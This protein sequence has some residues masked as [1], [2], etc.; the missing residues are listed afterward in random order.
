MAQQ[1]GPAPE[2]R[3]VDIDGLDVA[4]LD[5][6]EGPL[7]LLLHGYPDTARGWLPVMGRL[8]DAGYRAVAPSL[9][10]YPPSGSSPTGDYSAATNA[11]IMLALTQAL[12][13]DRFHLCGLDWG[14][15]IAFS[16]AHLDPAAVAE[17]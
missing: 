7:I 2:Y 13:A 15:L 14:Y 3:H 4:Y 6:G 16:V 5:V 8:A 9:P 12:G 1:E 17:S 10:G 11:G